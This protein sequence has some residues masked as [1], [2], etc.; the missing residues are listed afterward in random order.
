MRGSKSR[1]II[2]VFLFLAA[3]LSVY[4][5]YRESRE[6]YLTVAFLD[7]GQGDAIFIEAPN[8]NQMLIDGGPDKA[9]LRELSKVMPFYDRTIDAVLLTHADQDHAGGLPDVLKK[10]KTD[11]FMESG[12]SGESSSYEEVEK[13]V[14]ENEA[15]SSS[16]ESKIGIKKVLAKKGMVVDLGNNVVLQILS[17]ANV[18]DGMETN[19]ASVVAKLIYGEN[20]FLL[21]GDAPIAIENYLVSESQRRPL[22]DAPERASLTLTSDVLKVGHHGSKT[23]T[24]QEFVSSV[25][26][27]YVVI[28]VGK[29]NKYN[30]PSQE[31]LDTLNKFGAKIFRTDQSSHIIFKS[32]GVNLDL[33]KI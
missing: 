1:L 20:E 28:S 29:D 13:I 31:T 22:K 33:T 7:V 32:D 15:S 16:P 18:F 3:V 27:E 24:S 5:L 30:H 11:I 9:I 19:K 8:G 21:T 23:S 4:I 17:P 12:V 10:Y 6:G 26:P 14:I 25:S 2:L